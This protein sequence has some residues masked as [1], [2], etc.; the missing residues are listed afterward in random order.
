MALNLIQIEKNCLKRKSNHLIQMIILNQFP[1]YYLKLHVE[2]LVIFAPYFFPQNHLLK[3]KK[4]ENTV[5][6]SQ[7][8]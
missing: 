8:M 1:K 3:Q 5:V 7:E 4:D 6:L 2:Y